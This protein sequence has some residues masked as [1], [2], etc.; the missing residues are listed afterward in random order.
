M[1]PAK[2]Y[3]SSSVSRIY[4]YS[5]P[6]MPSYVE[7]DPVVSKVNEIWYMFDRDRSGALNRNETLRFLNHM[8]AKEGK[9]SCTMH[10]FN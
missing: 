5:S 7:K 8:L 4:N 10:Y 2:N 9:P 6:I 3:E 1:V